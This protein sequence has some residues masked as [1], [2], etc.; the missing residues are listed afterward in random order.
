MW[1]PVLHFCLLA[2]LPGLN[3]TALSGLCLV[4]GDQSALLSVRP[5]PNTYGVGVRAQ[6]EVHG[7]LTISYHSTLHNRTSCTH[8]VNSVGTS[9]LWLPP[10][11]VS[12]NLEPQCPLR[13]MIR[14]VAFTGPESMLWDI[15][16]GL[17]VILSVK[18]GLE[19]GPRLQVDI[20]SG[21]C[22]LLVPWG[23]AMDRGS[24]D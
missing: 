19:G 5:S 24:S 10:Y 12:C 9:K 4:S 16:A 3:S 22:G 20:S 17:S 21:P 15:S 7:L 23:K 11:S 18:H 6:K 14:E 2:Q 8:V 1:T 13:R